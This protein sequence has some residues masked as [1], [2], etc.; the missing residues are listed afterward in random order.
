MRWELHTA[1]HLRAGHGE[2]LL[3]GYAERV[4]AILDQNGRSVPRS[5]GMVWAAER[6]PG[7][8]AVAVGIA[9]D[10]VSLIAYV[11]PADKIQ[12]QSTEPVTLEYRTD[13]EGGTAA[14]VLQWYEPPED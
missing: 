10:G 14:V 5:P 8:E 1:G 12:F 2:D 6:L 7:G 9:Q 3:R 11:W 13:D 4:K